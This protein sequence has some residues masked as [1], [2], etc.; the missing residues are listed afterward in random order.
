MQQALIRAGESSVR[1]FALPFKIQ[2]LGLR[3]MEHGAV[4]EQFQHVHLQLIL[5]H[6]SFA[7]IQG[8]KPFQLRFLV[9]IEI[10]I[11]N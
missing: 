4:F 7:Y 5:L 9:Q 1:W 10:E 11:E 6:C 2:R 8:Q 3:S